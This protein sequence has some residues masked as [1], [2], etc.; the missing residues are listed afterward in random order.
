MLNQDAC[1]FYDDVALYKQF[2][3]VVLDAAEGKH[4]AEA[5]GT[6]KVGRFLVPGTLSDSVR[7]M[8]GWHFAS[9]LLGCLQF[10]QKLTMHN[11]TTDSSPLRTPSRQLFSSILP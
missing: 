3:G 2:N 7:F 10:F 1:A 8:L 6:K 4:I 11:R 9:E 5:L